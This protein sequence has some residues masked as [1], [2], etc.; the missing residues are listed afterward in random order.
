MKLHSFFLV[1]NGERIDLPANV[2][3]T[4][5]AEEQAERQAERTGKPVMFFATTLLGECRPIPVST[6]LNAA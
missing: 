4:S 2:D 6:E 3:C 5:L 1:V